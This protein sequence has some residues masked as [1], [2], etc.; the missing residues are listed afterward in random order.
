VLNAVVLVIVIESIYCECIVF[1][2]EHDYEH[3]HE[4]T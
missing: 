2:Y 3:E 4:R 1:D